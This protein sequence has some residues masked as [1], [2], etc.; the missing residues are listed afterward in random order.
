MVFTSLWKCSLL[1]DQGSVSWDMNEFLETTGKFSEAVFVH[2][3]LGRLS[4]TYIHILKWVIDSEN[5]KDHGKW[6][7]KYIYI[8]TIDIIHYIYIYIKKLNIYTVD[9]CAKQELG[10]L[11]PQHSWK[12]T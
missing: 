10:S 9:S 4:I 3:F 1:A 2:N 8:Y 6:V 5:I 11:T 12:S 7:K